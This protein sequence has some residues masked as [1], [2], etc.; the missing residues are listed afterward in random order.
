M[1]QPKKSAE[2]ISDSE[3]SSQDDADDIDGLAT[4][5]VSPLSTVSDDQRLLAIRAVHR[6]VYGVRPYNY[7]TSTA[8]GSP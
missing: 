4:P 2:F 6:T 3:N 8:T 5:S 7:G 1:G